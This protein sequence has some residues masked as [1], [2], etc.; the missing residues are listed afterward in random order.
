MKSRSNS[1]QKGFT[2]VEMALVLVIIGLVLGAVSIGKDLQRTSEYKKVKQKF[3]DQWVQAYNQYY[4]RT[5]VVL[6]DDAA[7]PTMAVNG[8]VD[9]FQT[10]LL[11]V[12]DGDYS[13]IDTDIA[14]RICQG[15]SNDAYEG[16]RDAQSIVDPG[17]VGENI[18]TSQNLHGYFDNL[19]IRMPPGRAE[20]REDRYVYLDSNGNPQEIQICF[21][22]NPPGT[23]SNAGNVM[24]IS[25]L[26]PDLAR[27]L[28][29]MVDGQANALRGAFR[30]QGRT[31]DGNTNWTFT[32]IDAA[33]TAAAA[34]GTG[35][36]RDEDQVIIVTAH[37]KMNQ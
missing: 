19:G 16:S 37:Y 32:N 9:Q 14:G 12:T 17:G 22:W 2:L 25:G 5:G 1:L 18:E 26:T 8:D 27:M 15:E 21:Q 28:D 11:G 10:E 31:D 35:T 30:E 33:G 13:G 24:V 23:V 6:G 3:V 20:G 29:E 36:A 34:A 7:V 4:I